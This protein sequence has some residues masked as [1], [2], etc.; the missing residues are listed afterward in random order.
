MAT[1]EKITRL[2]DMAAQFL[3]PD[4]EGK[5]F[6]NGA[7][8][9]LEKANGKGKDQPLSCEVENDQLLIRIGVETLK[10]CCNNPHSAPEK[11][12]WLITDAEG[13]AK[14]VIHE[15]TDERED[16]ST[17][18]TDLI[19]LAVEKAKENGSRHMEE[20]RHKAAGDFCGQCGLFIESSL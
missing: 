9:E 6:F 5:K 2:R 10:F 1:T 17:I 8:D 14:D 4:A 13:F 11:D 20:C 18:L 16:G 15:L 7:A 19:D 3:T 12:G